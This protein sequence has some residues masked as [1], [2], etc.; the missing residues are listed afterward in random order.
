MKEKDIIKQISVKR[1]NMDY[2]GIS[3]KED[4]LQRIS[5]L[6]TQ[7]VEDKAISNL[8][9]VL[10]QSR[11]TNSFGNMPESKLEEFFNIEDDFQ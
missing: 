9:N 10:S 5:V 8:Y 7:K 4:K 1:R 11:L 2:G 6:G 3:N